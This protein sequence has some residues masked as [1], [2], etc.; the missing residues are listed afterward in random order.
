LAIV[1]ACGFDLW[2]PPGTD[3]WIVMINMTGSIFFMLSAIGAFVLPTGEVWSESLVAAGTFVGA[4]CFLVGA[5]LLL[6]E[7]AEEPKVAVSATAA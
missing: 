7:A 1:E 3:W 4:I 6:P 2:P 5:Y